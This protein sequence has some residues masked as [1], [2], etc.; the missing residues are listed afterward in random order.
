MAKLQKIRML[1]IDKKDIF[2]IDTTLD[3][4]IDGLFGKRA[5]AAPSEACYGYDLFE[6]EIRDEFV[7]S[8][9]FD[10]AVCFVL[11]VKILL[12]ED[13]FHIYFLKIY[14]YLEV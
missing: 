6:G 2:F 7:Q 12:Y 3:K 11:P 1:Q 9:S 10:T 14:V 8:F 5:F 13:I 4:I